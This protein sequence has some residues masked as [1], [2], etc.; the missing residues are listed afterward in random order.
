[1]SSNAAIAANL[2]ELLPPLPRS[3]VDE[4]AWPA[5]PAAGAA[6][7]F[8]IV[9]Q[10][11]RTQWLPH[12][13][14]EAAQLAQLGRLLDYSVAHVPFY[15]QPLTSA[16]Y[17]PGRPLT[18]AAWRRLPIL[19]RATAAAA[20][21][22]LLGIP[23]PAGHGDTRRLTTS[24]TT[25]T[26][27]GVVKTQLE[28]LFW[29]AFTLR[30]ELWH[31]R[32]WQGSL[33][34]I[35][36]YPNG[37]NGPPEGGT[38]ASWG[39]PL[40]DLYPTGPVYRL[41][42]RTGIAEQA[43]WLA[44]RDPDYLLTEAGNLR[45]LANRFRSAGLRL[46]RLKQARAIRGV[47]DDALRRA[48]RESWGVAV[49]D[50]YSCT[51]I[52]NLAFACP[53]HGRLHVQMEGAMVEILDRAGNPCPPG[54]VGEVV[55]TPLH[56]FAMPFIRYALGDLAEAGPPCPCGRGLATIARVVGRAG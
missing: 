32:H 28:Q 35:R 37:T 56:N 49:A 36:A 7:L 5:V 16:G 12:A 15:R 25:D 27:L 24:G 38:A 6:T 3:S 9:H 50:L 31:R 44:R 55:A 41:D 43:Q 20:G 48:C 33:A 46:T 23:T 53:E 13:D 8:A 11:A 26:P 42:I 39:P 47:V 10:L 30:E 18:I 29:Q 45:L 34:V 19:R 14:L 22:A 1:M 54:A 51:E 21:D 52:G 2:W 17:R 4:V 40:A